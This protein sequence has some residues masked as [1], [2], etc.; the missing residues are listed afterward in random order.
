[1]NRKLLVPRG[2]RAVLRDLRPKVGRKFQVL[3]DKAEAGQT[4]ARTEHDSPEVDNEV[5]IPTEG[6]YL[7]IG[8]FAQV[9][10]TGAREHE[11]VG[12]VV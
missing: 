7:R 1:M 11:L 3:V 5:L 12:E 4:I 6:T 10:I 8:D 2:P 9:R